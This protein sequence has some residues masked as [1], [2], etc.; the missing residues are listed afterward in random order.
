MPLNKRNRSAL[1]RMCILIWLV[2]SLIKTEGG[3]DGFID[4]MMFR[5]L[6]QQFN[7]TQEYVAGPLNLP[8]QQFQLGGS[9]PSTIHI[10]AIGNISYVRDDIIIYDANFFVTAWI[11]EFLHDLKGLNVTTSYDKDIIT[12]VQRAIPALH[13]F[14]DKNHD[15]DNLAVSFWLQHKQN[16]TNDTHIYC[17]TTE[18]LFRPL[19]SITDAEVDLIGALLIETGHQDLWNVL[20]PILDG[21]AGYIRVF[22]IPSDFDDTSVALALS[23]MFLQHPEYFGKETAALWFK[24]K[25]TQNVTSYAENLSKYA[26][27]PLSGDKNVNV[28]D[29]RV[30]YWLRHFV[31]N[32][33]DDTQLAL[34]V[35]WQM[36]LEDIQYYNK[37]NYCYQTPF[38]ANNVDISVGANVVFALARSLV[39]ASKFAE[40]EVD[41]WFTEDIQR[42]YRNTTNAII[43]AIEDNWVNLRPEI[44]FLYYPS[45]SDF[46]WFTS[47]TLL[48]YREIES[49][50]EYQWI[51]RKYPFIYDLY[52]KLEDTMKDY[53]T[54]QILSSVG[55]EEDA[56]GTFYFWDAFIGHADTTID[57]K[58]TPHHYDRIFNTA[59]YSNA[60]LYIWSSF[61]V[62]WLESVPQQVQTVLKGA[63]LFLRTQSFDTVKYKPNN[64]FFSGSVKT[65][66]NTWPSPYPINL[67]EYTNGSYHGT[68]GDYCKDWSYDAT[69]A[70]EGFIDDGMYSELIDN[71]P[72]G[73]NT[74]SQF[75]GW[76]Q[77]DH[78]WPYWT[79]H[80]VTDAATL[81]AVA[82]Y[83]V[84]NSTQT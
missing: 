79:S 17:A 11:L 8:T 37:N 83:D 42:I 36:T 30:Y 67:F 7:K 51:F 18:N 24:E 45:K 10:N 55:Y 19:E 40:Q 9:F 29:T 23:T 70:V 5:L 43:Y 15:P 48:L 63:N 84:I 46:Y 22:G 54:D 75:T 78:P 81:L 77:Y 61:D 27:R 14:K 69:I 73:L 66:P 3:S 50:R 31:E 57:N 52:V 6:R 44:V 53:A 71:K 60:L 62:K 59:M 28:M 68:T 21:R 64:A 80:A 34:A 1:S 38:Q 26:Y 49:T 58:P 47:R 16:I 41:T 32:N 20:K 82:R 76:N 12:T 13:L 25:W 2:F 35:T 74:P 56:L 4:R 65:V 72:C 39:T 33:Q